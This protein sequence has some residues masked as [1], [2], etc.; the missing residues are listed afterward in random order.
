M[1]PWL[2][3]VRRRLR[4]TGPL[5][6]GFAIA[7]A[8]A[9]IAPAAAQSA[10]AAPAISAYNSWNFK[11]SGLDGA[12]FQNVIA[13]SPF[14]DPSYAKPL[15]AGADVAGIHRSLDGGRTWTPSN[16]GL[17]DKHV[18]S[19]MWDK[20]T[21]G[22][23]YAA[24]DSGINVSTDF[25][26]NWVRRPAPVDF[27]ANGKW[28]VVGTTEHP[29]ATGRLLAQ[30]LDGTTKL[31]WAATA[32][33]GIKRSSDDGLTWSVVQLAGLH[34][35][36]VAV[37]PNNP[38]VMYVAAANSGLYVSTN[39]RGAMTF[40]LV[41]GS[42][43]NPEEISFINRRL[44]VSAH[45]AGVFSYDGTWHLLSGSFLPNAAWESIAG[46]RG[47]AGNTVLYAGSAQVQ[48]GQA[49]MRSVDGGLTWASIS[50]GVGITVSE[51]M[52]GSTSAWWAK[53]LPYQRFAGPNWVA[54]QIIVDPSDINSVLIA[55]RGGIWRGTSTAT[56][57]AWAPAVKGLSVTVNM[58]TVA[59]P[60]VAGRMFIGSMDYTS[61]GSA[62]GAVNIVNS[63]PVGVPSTGDV[64]TLD[65]GAT[66]AGLPSAVYLG[67]SERGT[68]TGIGGVWSNP[69][70]LG[71]PTAWQSEGL[72]VSSDV[73]ALG[74]GHPVTGRVILAGVTANGLWR[75]SGD[76]WTQITG[77][78]PFQTGSTGSF[79]WV[80][81]S[82]TVYAIDGA[83]V[84]RSLAGGDTGTWVKLMGGAATYGTLDALRVNPVQP[85][86]VFVSAGSLGGVWR[87]DNADTLP[88]AP[89]RILALGNP[90]PIAFDSAGR[91]FVHDAGI[92]RLLRAVTPGA[93][94]PAFTTVSDAFYAD[95]NAR[96]RSLAI[97]PD[98]YIYTA[99]NGAG[100]TVGV[101][102]TAVAKAYAR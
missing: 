2:S 28:F 35:R 52:Y 68:N 100:V 14:L 83:G 98:G 36:S 30:G 60:K 27:D 87:I 25:G 77:V 42:P 40:T 63:K 38:D 67:A 70:P 3:P 93:A 71:T 56:T 29:R 64:V 47:T 80:P 32:T 12:G 61:L 79:A 46:Y 91:L 72:P 82:S 11:L 85:S 57:T 96:I 31:L 58:A 4:F 88:S 73:T 15:I 18:A 59:D 41:P 19:L 6:A 90:G 45:T 48:G 24:T 13:S 69:D 97:G 65:P 99:S 76:T 89:V 17:G 26:L 50:S 7:S 66:G 54:A 37:D 74:V 95:N 34:L 16:R 44:Y 23:V 9:L 102:N 10:T 86:S 8:V 20:T 92:S 55:G 21:A 78:A 81:G 94:A 75:K 1:T 62:N 101:P 51:T 39:A 33:Q 84:W 5:L 22:K 53:D 43:V 49:V